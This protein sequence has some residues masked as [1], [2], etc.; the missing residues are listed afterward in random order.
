MHSDGQHVDKLNDEVV[1]VRIRLALT[2]GSSRRR[3]AAA[4]AVHST[5]Q[6]RRIA[7]EPSC[8]LSS[9][10]EVLRLIFLVHFT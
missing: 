8:S 6:L 9:S 10:T 1:E 7:Q 5:Q 3:R 4:P 2:A